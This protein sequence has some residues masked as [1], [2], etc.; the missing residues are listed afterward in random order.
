MRCIPKSLLD[1]SMS[2]SVLE[3]FRHKLVKMLLG[4]GVYGVMTSSAPVRP[5]IEY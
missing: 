4:I 5:A 3:G 1:D 2:I